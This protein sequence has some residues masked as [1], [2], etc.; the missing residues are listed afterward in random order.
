MSETASDSANSVQSGSE[1]GKESS[2]VKLP[3]MP[4]Q[5][6]EEASP[7]T[8]TKKAMPHKKSDS[9]AGDNSQP[10]QFL[11]ELLKIVEEENKPSPHDE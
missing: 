10:S 8:V 11:A 1:L 6:A 7:Q 5:E 9:I 2:A 3:H 4:A